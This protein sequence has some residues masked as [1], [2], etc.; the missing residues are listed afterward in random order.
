MKI[1]IDNK[2]GF[3]FGVV[4]A[5]KAAEE[6]L[7]NQTNLYSLGDIVHNNAEVS[8]L[9]AVGMKVID[10]KN[11]MEKLSGETVLIRA[12]GEPPAT[13]KMAKKYNV[14]LIDATCPVVLKLQKKI[15]KGYLAMKR[16]K[17][18][19]AIFGKKGHAEVIGLAG[20]TANNALIISE[21]SEIRFINYSKPLRLY[22]QTTQSLS[23]YKALVELIK[24]Q[25]SLQGYENPDFIWF[26]TICRQVS[27]RETNL[28]KFAM[29]HKVIIFVSGK[30]SS[31]GLHLFQICKSVNNNSYMVSSENDILIGWFD[32]CKHVG[33]CGATSTPMWLMK[34][35]GEKIMSITQS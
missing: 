26:D 18:K 35:V 10:N 24:K 4:L 21:P 25:Y 32:D 9:K 17:G 29:K 30:D 28:K 31:N 3:C 22:A 1:T 23:D 20:Q 5:I 27:N 12:H 34:S 11:A 15:R 2:S 33:I 19:I 14:S 7:Q 13:Y 16:K 6:A 8:R